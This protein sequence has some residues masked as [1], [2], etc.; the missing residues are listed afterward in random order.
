M[1]ET[2]FDIAG[3]STQDDADAVLFE[4]Q[5][6]PCV[7]QAEVH[8]AVRQAWVSHTAMIAPEDIAA[9]LLAAG[10]EA[11]WPGSPECG[12]TRPGVCREAMAPTSAPRMR[13][14]T[15][16]TMPRS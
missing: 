4:L 15:V 10:Y 11:R 9:A 8:L 16:S 3:L 1:P 12:L 2:V 7:Q 13:R 5:D 6:L 14:C